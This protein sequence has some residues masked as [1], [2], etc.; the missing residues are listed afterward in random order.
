MIWG[1]N[2]KIRKKT[3][4][5]AHRLSAA[6]GDHDLTP[7][8]G[9]L[10]YD[11]VLAV[12]SFLAN[13]HATIFCSLSPLPVQRSA[14][15]GVSAARVPRSPEHRLPQGVH[16]SLSLRFAAHDTSFV[17]AL[18]TQI[19]RHKALQYFVCEEVRL[20]LHKVVRCC[21]RDHDGGHT[22]CTA[23]PWLLR[24]VR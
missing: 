9:P 18:C 21:L 15:T 19:L 16:R 17:H 13:K 14:T 24:W 4:L 8:N 2:R 7:L 3:V 22:F 12:V 6:M 5:T 23:F 1:K 11:G 20:S 10:D